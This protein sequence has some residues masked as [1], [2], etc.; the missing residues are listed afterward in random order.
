MP[1]AKPYS[2]REK[3]PRNRLREWREE[4]GLSIAEVAGLSG[5]SLAM[6]SRAERGQRDFSLRGRVILA[7]RLGVPIETLFP[8]ALLTDDDAGQGL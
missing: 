7:R 2:F 1:T 6:I 8:V 5:F 3:P 4:A